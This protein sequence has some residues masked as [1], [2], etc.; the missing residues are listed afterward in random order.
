M[1][2]ERGRVTHKKQTTGISLSFL[3]WFAFSMFALMVVVVFALVQNALVTRQY[4]ESV[5]AY[6]GDTGEQ[7][8]AEI[9]SGQSASTL[10]Q[11]L[12]T[13]ANN[14]G[15]T[16]RLFYENG[17]NAFTFTSQTED[18]TRLA[19][20]LVERRNAGTLP[21]FL[22]SGND[23]IILAVVTEVE[24]RPA[25]LCLTASTQLH[26]AL[27]SGMRWLSLITA[28]AAIVLAFVV[29]GIVTSFITRPLT[30]VTARAK[31]MARGNYNINFK[32]DYFC[33]EIGELS[34]A[35]EYA[36]TEISRADVMQKE[37]IANV[38]HDFKTPLTMIKA[39]ASMIR[40]ISG[41]NK[42][43]RDAH[44]QIIIDECDR[45]TLLVSD[46]LDL[47]K[48]RA[49][50]TKDNITHFDLSEEVREV[51][52]RF[53]YLKETEGLII[54]T[55]IEDD[56]FAD[57]DKERIAQVLYNLIGNAVNYT[58]EDDKRI[59]IKLFRKEHCARFEVIDTG[60]GIPADEVDTIWD[61]Y[62]RSGRTHKRAV[63]GTGLGLSIVKNILL[64]HN[65]PF[66]VISEEGKGSCFWVE[67]PDGARKQRG[68]SD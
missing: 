8:L 4:R 6:M 36:R 51:A 27:E 46:L 53:S 28:L 57:A 15:C 7:M 48:L 35:L 62:Y 61:R 1:G 34:D 54:E 26:L 10:E 50:L 32:K 17:E 64:Q 41:D 52:E 19:A 13:I 14:N 37:L 40:E 21:D 39:Y 33:A 38:S 47:S 31:E 45:L 9:A 25:F 18:F 59:R 23:E 68:S 30:E 12:L 20:D 65:F 2:S 49:G 66:G 3:L 60:K 58:G 24:G 56:I 5:L 67:F 16:V 29:S 43:K 22:I 55:E 42:Q 44:A 63:N 11:R